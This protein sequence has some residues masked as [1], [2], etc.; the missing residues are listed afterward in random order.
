MMDKTFWRIRSIGR[1]YDNLNIE[2]VADTAS[3]TVAQTIEQAAAAHGIE[4]ERLAE[5]MPSWRPVVA[6]PKR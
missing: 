4:L 2:L 6:E 3:E 1:P 5:P